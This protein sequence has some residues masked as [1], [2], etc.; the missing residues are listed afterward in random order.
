[1][2]DH[3]PNR[4]KYI[5]LHASRLKFLKLHL[6]I[7]RRFSFTFQD[8]EKFQPFERL[9]LHSYRWIHTRQAALNHWDWS[10]LTH[11]HLEDVSIY[12]FLRSVPPE[13]LAQLLSFCTDGQCKE[14]DQ[15]ETTDLMCNLILRIRELQVL[16]LK[17]LIW[18]FQPEVIA[19]HGRTLHKLHLLNYEKYS[20]PHSPAKTLSSASLEYLQR[21]CPC[22]EDL[23]LAFDPTTTNVS[24]LGDPQALLLQKKLIFYSQP[25]AWFSILKSFPHVQ[26]ITIITVGP[27]EIS[28]IDHTK[29]GNFLQEFENV[30]RQ[31]YPAMF[32]QPFFSTAKRDSNNIRKWRWK[33]DPNDFH[34]LGPLYVERE[35][36]RAPREQRD[37]ANHELIQ[38]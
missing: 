2:R 30:L 1:M 17:C 26:K 7:S 11:L 31:S 38:T 29:M 18:R 20:A 15:Q 14:K 9:A 27:L 6:C 10:R 5:I 37:E 19:K 25:T 4:L 3:D 13:E 22:L 28:K 34:V 21:K 23:M 32:Q 35:S 33:R 24:R 36:K 12:H 8:G 16:E